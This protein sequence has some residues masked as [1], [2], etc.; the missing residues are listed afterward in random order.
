MEDLADQVERA[1]ELGAALARHG[2][3]PR[4]L[5]EAELLEIAGV[6]IV[7]G[8]VLGEEAVVLRRQGAGLVLQAVGQHARLVEQHEARALR[9]QLGVRAVA[10]GD[11]HRAAR[12]VEHAGHGKLARADNGRLR[13][14]VV[15][16][17]EAHLAVAL[18]VVA[19]GG[20]GEVDAILGQQRDA[21]GCIDAHEVDIDPQ[22]ASDRQ[23]HVDLVALTPVAL[24]FGKQR[25][26][27]ADADADLLGAQDLDQTV[28]VGLGAGRR[29]LGARLFE[30]LGQ[31]GIGG[32]GAGGEQRRRR[33]RAPKRR[34]P[35][36]ETAILSSRAQ[37]GT[38]PAAS[39]VPRLRPRD[40]SDHCPT[41][42]CL[43]ISTMCIS[44][45]A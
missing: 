9:H 12:Q 33:G 11:A 7:V 32:C 18:G 19:H 10:D 23:R 17:D 45:K 42:S 14:I 41:A 37:R 6:E 2:H 13:P 44:P 36:R 25:V 4:H 8:E 29:Q 39:K 16:A 35:S 27:V 30:Q 34:A 43:A 31:G 22:H 1:R 15:R 20:D 26:V 24:A 38:F 21:G 3:A 5:G 40:D 28:D